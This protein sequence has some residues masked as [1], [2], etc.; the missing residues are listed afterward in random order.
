MVKEWNE[1]ASEDEVERTIEALKKNG[2]NAF[3]VQTKEEAKEKALEMIPDDAEIF[4]M[5]SMTL[6][7][8][9]IDKEINESHL[10]KPVRNIMNDPKDLDKRDLK[11]IGAAPEYVIGSVHAVTQEGAVLIASNTGS[12]LPAYAYGSDKVIW[13][14][15]TAKIV[16]DTDEGIK[17][18]YEHSL[19]LEKE[20]AKEAY[21]IT[22]AVSKILIINK[23]VSPQRINIIFVNEV[24]GY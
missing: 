23:E 17:R 15:S 13:V 21:G 5:T 9:G 1:L 20:R 7:A 10:Y 14:V 12:Q 8:C 19:P 2:I 22:S 3:L 11:K 4:T 18:I 16:E 24:L 6:E